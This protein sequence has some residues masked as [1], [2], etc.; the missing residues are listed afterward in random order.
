MKIF[1]CEKCGTVVEELRLGG[2]HPSCCGEAM[3]EMI[4]GSSDG[5]FDKHVPVCKVEGNHV[6]V[7][8]GSTIHPMSEPHYIEWVAIET[9]SGMQRHY[10][11]PHC[12]PEAEFLI[13]EDESV[14]AVYAYCNL[15]GLWTGE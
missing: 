15:H 4:P 10:F 5:A 7:T 9:E 13:M 6:T 14:K 12:Y 11:T 1:K 3:K 8:V 2:C